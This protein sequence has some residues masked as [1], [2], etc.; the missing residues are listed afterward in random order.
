MVS[1]EALPHSI[2]CEYLRATRNLTARHGHY[3]ILETI[4]AKRLEHKRRVPQLAVHL[5]LGD[6]LDVPPYSQ[7]CASACMYVYPL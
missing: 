1:V 4:V 5:R 6:T 2:A 3:D 7:W